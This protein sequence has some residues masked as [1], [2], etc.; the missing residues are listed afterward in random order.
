MI[1][2]GT[3]LLFNKNLQRHPYSLY[4]YG[5]LSCGAFYNVY[6]AQILIITLLKYVPSL[7]KAYVYLNFVDILNPA[8]ENDWYAYI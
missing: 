1:L 3:F 7:Y 6:Y 2:I 8:L 4:A 5:V